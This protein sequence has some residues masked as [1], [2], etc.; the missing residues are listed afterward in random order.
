MALLWRAASLIFT[1]F[2]ALMA[3]IFV[4]N[5]FPFPFSQINTTISFLVLALSVSSDKKI[6]LLVFLISYLSSLFS[7]IPF[8]IGIASTVISLLV[9][10][11]FQL[12][13]LTNRSGY[14]VFL[15][16]F[17]GITLYKFLFILFLTLNNYFF[18]QDVM[19]YG[20]IALDSVWEIVLSSIVFFII[21]LF[22]AKFFK[23]PNPVYIKYE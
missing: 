23:R 14:M 8:G 6:I 19:S 10:R 21:Y 4:I 3:Q 7:S 12:N 9:I 5:F 18:R 1:V 16:L 2:L 13:I 11:W 22:S 17:L 15:S 20:E